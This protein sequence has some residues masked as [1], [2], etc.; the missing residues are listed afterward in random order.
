MDD[1]KLFAKIK[2]KIEFLVQTVHIFSEDIDIQ[3]RIRK[4]GILTLERG[5]VVRTYGIRLPDGRDMKDMNDQTERNEGEVQLRVFAT[6]K[7]DI[8]IKFE[9][10]K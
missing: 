10:K 9:W 6:S 2:N 5:K 1:L 3:L 8:K 4:Y 7:T